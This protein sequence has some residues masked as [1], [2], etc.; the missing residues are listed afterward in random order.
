[1]AEPIQTEDGTWVD[2]DTGEIVD[3]G[4]YDFT[5]AAGVEAV[6]EI[7]QA[8]DSEVAG[9]NSRLAAQ[10]E[11]IGRM[12]KDRE[13][14]RNFLLS[15]YMQPLEVFAA[16]QLKG[17][18]R[19]WKCPFGKIGFRKTTGSLKVA[20]GMSAEAIAFCEEHFPDAVKRDPR[21]VTTPLKGHEADLPPEL[22]DVEW[23]RDRFYV[24][25]G[26]EK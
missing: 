6:L 23:P 9:L 7:I 13:D 24:D 14:K 15:R 8:I 4:G 21:L 19:S 3:R 16:A 26:V 10:Q 12:I 1:M 18:E 2:P 11:L 22:F 25:T 17:K 5:T 20:D